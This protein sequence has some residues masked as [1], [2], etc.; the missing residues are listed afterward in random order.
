MEGWIGWIG[1]MDDWMKGYATAGISLTVHLIHP[2]IDSVFPRSIE[3][4]KEGRKE[5]AAINS[6][7]AACGV[8]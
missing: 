4:R 7:Q 2:L 8:E 5:G 3:G 1:C 6:S